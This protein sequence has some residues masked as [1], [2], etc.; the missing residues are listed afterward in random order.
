MDSN[1]EH[2]ASEKYDEVL[3]GQ[4]RTRAQGCKTGVIL[5]A[6]NTSKTSC[7]FEAGLRRRKCRPAAGR[8]LLGVMRLSLK[9]RNEREI[10]PSA[11]RG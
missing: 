7:A 8:D 1:I 9:S 4:A 2:R 6:K 5:D 3:F 10:M 11:M